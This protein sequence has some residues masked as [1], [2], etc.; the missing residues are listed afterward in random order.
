MSWTYVVTPGYRGVIE[1]DG[2]GRVTLAP[3]EMRWA[4]GTDIDELKAYLSRNEQL[5]DWHQYGPSRKET[6]TCG[7]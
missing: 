2:E 7:G 3:P 6:C 4:L 5:R 1:F